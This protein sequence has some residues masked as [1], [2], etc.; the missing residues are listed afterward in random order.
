MLAW[1]SDL[2]GNEDTEMGLLE[3]FLDREAVG[4]ALRLKKS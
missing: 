4:V 2:V 1:F 3:A